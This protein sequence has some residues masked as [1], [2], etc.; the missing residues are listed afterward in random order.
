MEKMKNDWKKVT[1][2]IMMIISSSLALMLLIYLMF[3]I[4]DTTYGGGTSSS[5]GGY[6]IKSLIQLV[7]TAIFIGII[8]YTV[9]YYRNVIDKGSAIL[10][11]IVGLVLSVIMFKII[12]IVLF[13]ISITFTIIGNEV[14]ANQ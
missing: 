11:G 7:F 12:L 6:M 8:I 13:S 5:M 1:G 4:D 14:A 2:V 9:L 10:M 3:I